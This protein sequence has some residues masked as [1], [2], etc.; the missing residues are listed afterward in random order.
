MSNKGVFITAA[1]E[2]HERRDVACFDI[3]GAYLHTLNDEVVHMLLRGKLAKMMVMMNP[4][5]YRKYVTYSANGT[6]L[7]YVLLNKALYGLLRSALLFYEKLVKDLEDNGFEINPYDPCVANKMV[8]GHQMTVCWH[9]DDLK[10][11]HKDPKEITKFAVY[12]SSIYG[13]KLTVHRG[14]VHDYLGVDFDYSE[15]GKVK[16]S[17]IKYLKGVIDEFPE[18][19]PTR[20]AATPASDN[21]FK[22]R[23]ENDPAYRPLPK[24]KARQFHHTVAQL[25]FMSSR[26]RRDI[27]TTVAFLT[28]RVKKPD[29]DDWG[30]LR[31]CLSYLKGT[32]YMKLTLEVNDLRVVE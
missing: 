12:L 2:A 8:G 26:S 18:D 11:S 5:M 14:K 1:I 28:T 30:K 19:L 6:P 16:I 15:S 10:V 7:L 25:L 32:R 13:E 29:E 21:L 17:M 4:G 3:P 24:E 9:V 23:D 22:V 27:Q 31:R 20:H